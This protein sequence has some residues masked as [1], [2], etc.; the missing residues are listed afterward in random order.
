M[1]D[2]LRSTLE[3][4]ERKV[5]ITKQVLN[6]RRKFD[7]RA[8]AFSL[9]AGKDPVV[10]FAFKQPSRWCKSDHELENRQANFLINLYSMWYNNT[11]Y[12]SQD[13][14]LN[15]TNFSQLRNE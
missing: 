6:K 11:A 2:L 3:D 8:R 15:T 9:K 12:E 1:P 4:S 5:W 13:K 14:L 7:F 10:L